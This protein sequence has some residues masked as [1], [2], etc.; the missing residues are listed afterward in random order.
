MIV[1]QIDLEELEK[2]LKKEALFR[3]SR[4]LENFTRTNLIKSFNISTFDESHLAG[5][6]TGTFE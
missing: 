6:A 3:A 2:L 1:T 5:K 4:N